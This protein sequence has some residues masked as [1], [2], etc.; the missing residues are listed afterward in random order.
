MIKFSIVF[1]NDQDAIDAV[2]TVLDS[3]HGRIQK[4]CIEKVEYEEEE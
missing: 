4:V 2:N 1:I 3:I